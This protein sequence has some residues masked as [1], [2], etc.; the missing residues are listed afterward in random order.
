MYYFS[1]FAHVASD[2]LNDLGVIISVFDLEI[3]TFIVIKENVGREKKNSHVNRQL[4]SGTNLKRKIE[5][6]FDGDRFVPI[7]K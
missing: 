3:T 5:Y 2:F 1:N 7:G 4:I 6:V